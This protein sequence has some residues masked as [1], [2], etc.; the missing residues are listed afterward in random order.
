MLF[1]KALILIALG[2]FLLSLSGCASLKP[3]TTQVKTDSE[4]KT[5]R[6]K[7]PITKEDS[8]KTTISPGDEKTL[9]ITDS[10]I[11]RDTSVEQITE[12]EKLCD[13]LPTGPTM[14]AE[15]SERFFSCLQ[16]LEKEGKYREALQEMSNTLSHQLPLPVLLKVISEYTRLLSLSGDKAGAKSMWQTISLHHDEIQQILSEA[17]RQLRYYETVNGLD[18]ET[19]ALVEKLNRAYLEGRNYQEISKLALKLLKKINYSPLRKEIKKIVSAAWERDEVQ[20]QKALTELREQFLVHHQKEQSLSELEI[21]RQRYP[22]HSSKDYDDLWNW[23]AQWSEG[24]APPTDPKNL[25]QLAK[26]ADSLI[27]KGR[28][29]KAQSL[30]RKLLNTPFHAESQRKMKESGERFC[31]DKRRMASIY[32]KDSRNK[33]ADSLKVQLLKRASAEL[34]SCLLYFP[35]LKIANKVKKN[36]TLIQNQLQQLTSLKE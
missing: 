8:S 33:K 31:S 19:K 16:Q 27:E 34:D 6:E 29:I 25:D 4:Q 5:D 32:F 3:G 21:I 10:V 30:L 26:K 2:T 35:D 18:G 20:V 12:W 11:A 24:A 36:R 28:Y 17:G 22:S 13:T 7:I 23:I 1:L 15:K 9:I 14:K